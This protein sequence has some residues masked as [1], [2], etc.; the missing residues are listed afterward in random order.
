MTLTMIPAM[1]RILAMSLKS[2][3]ETDNDNDLDNDSDYDTC[4]GEDTGNVSEV[5]Q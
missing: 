5:S 1:A 3:N 2:L 4:N